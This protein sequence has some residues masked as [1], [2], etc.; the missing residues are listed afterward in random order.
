MSGDYWGYGNY[1]EDAV[2]IG[3]LP[4]LFAIFAVV[5]YIKRRKNG[6]D[7]DTLLNHGVMRKDLV[8]FLVLVIVVSLVLALGKNTPIFPWLYSYIPSFK[9]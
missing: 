4:V 7:R 1:W 6:Y 5:S 2:Y 3:L 8:I 9:L